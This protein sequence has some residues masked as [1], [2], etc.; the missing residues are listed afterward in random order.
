MI[1]YLNWVSSSTSFEYISSTFAAPVLCGT[2]AAAL[3]SPFQAN[4]QI[5]WY[6]GED[7]GPQNDH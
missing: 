4:P 2:A 3:L 7:S 1:S 5:T 6:S